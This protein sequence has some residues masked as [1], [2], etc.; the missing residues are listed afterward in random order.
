MKSINLLLFAG[1][2]SFLAN[3]SLSQS[4]CIDSSLIDQSIICPQVIDP[5]CGCDGVTYNNACEATYYY[6][7]T[8]YTPGSCG[9]NPCNFTFNTSVTD[10][11]CSYSCDGSITVFANGT[12]T[13]PFNYTYVWSNGV[14]GNTLEDLCCGSY[15][16]SAT[17]SLG[18]T[19]S[20]TITVTCP[21]ELQIT[22][23]ST[24]QTYQNPNSTGY[25]SITVNANG[26]AQGYL[27]SIDNGN[28]YQGSNTFYGLTA[29]IYIVQVM[30]D[31]GCI[32]IYTIEVAYV[33][34]QAS[35]TYTSGQSPCDIIF[36][37]TG[38][39][40]YTWDF[41]DGNSGYGQNVSHTYAGDG[42][43]IVSLGAYSA[44]GGWL[45]QLC[46]SIT[47]TI[48]VT[49]CGGSNPCQASFN[50]ADSNCIVEFYG[51]GASSYTWS[52]G[53]GTSG[54]GQY[55]YH[56][57]SNNGT[58]NV[59]MYAYNQNG[60]ICD[61]V[62]Q[63]V[64]VSGCNNTGG[65]CQTFITYTMGQT[66]C[67]YYFTATGANSYSWNFGDGNT[68]SGQTVSHTFSNDGIYFIELLGY[69]ANGVLCDSTGQYLTIVGCSGNTSCQASFNYVDSNCIVDFYG[70]GA[71]SYTWDFGD[72]TSGQGQYDYHT[73]TNNG[74]Y[75]VCMYAY[76]Q[77]GMICDTV[78]QNVYVSG[79]NNTGGGCQTYFTYT[80]GQSPCEYYFTATGATTYTWHFG[81]GN[82]GSGQTV[83]NT[84]SN[85]GMYYVLLMGYDSNGVL[86][87]SISQYLT[88]Q[89]C[90]GNNP[91]QAGYQF[92]IDS[93]CAYTFY[94]Y[95]AS[96]YEWWYDDMV[97]SGEIVT[98]Y[99]S[100]NSI[101]TLCMYAYD[102]QGF[103]C[104]TV[105]EDFVCDVTGIEELQN[106]FDVTISPNP[107]KSKGTILIQNNSPDQTIIQLMT[108]L[109]KRVET[110]YSGHLA[111]GSHEISWSNSNLVS[112]L[113][114][115]QISGS[116]G[117]INKRLLIQ[118]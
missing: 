88:I 3:Y 114:I 13:N 33:P 62:C 97:L 41:G 2:F 47:Q 30:D 109:G 5:V 116:F 65:G 32:A 113:Y 106:Q 73:Y 56:T 76:D 26:G 79:C 101:E 93:S 22:A 72:G 25:G 27:Y 21:P 20:T 100:P 67:E 103:L 91:C 43:Y 45:G 64:F 102:D 24:P 7:V 19:N 87:D 78:C 11:N 58:Y 69:N 96:S 80:M 86:C 55:E 61:T 99:I 108:P 35:I 51:S 77:N 115:V 17:D 59:C 82:T 118:R 18:C 85:D 52:F 9:G 74:T 66:P 71:S 16:V 12:T 23:S 60:M 39:D 110:I 28:S 112:G 104:D 105:C 46:D 50:Y 98:L 36:S 95:G 68:E 63:N 92:S 6:G 31:N 81:D 40:N 8:S 84:Y 37:A 38:A 107:A 94:G 44:N 89:G 48:T 29:G 57:Y 83:S 117:T 1:L 90:S 34:C 4:A 70:S 14:T 111:A 42:T 15:T 54:Q 75:N 53:D 10:P 49:G